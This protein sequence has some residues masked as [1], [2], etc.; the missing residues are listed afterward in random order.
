M[1]WNIETD[2]SNIITQQ[3]IFK[4]KIEILIKYSLLALI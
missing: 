3:N 4:T 2:N 1:Y